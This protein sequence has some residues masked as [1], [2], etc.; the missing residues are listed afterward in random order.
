MFYTA[1]RTIDNS[2]LLVTNT[3]DTSVNYCYCFH[4]SLYGAD[5]FLRVM[6]DSLTLNFAH[7][8]DNPSVGL[9][10][11]TDYSQ[12]KMYLGDTGLFITLAF[13]D[14]EV[15]ENIIYQ[16]LLSDKLST[17]LGYVYDNIVSQMFVASGNKLFYHTWSSETSNHNYEIDF[18]LSRGAKLWPLEMK[19]L[20]TTSI[21]PL[22]NSAGSSPSISAT[23][24]SSIP[25]ICAKIRNPPFFPCS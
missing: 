7:H 20:D 5:E 15:T 2:V 4:H 3:A 24:N 12:Y 11:H 21:N 10:A 9:P 6:E 17:D 8:A 13:W 22:T 25:R 16:K 23:D 14:K 19:S 18:L 1:S